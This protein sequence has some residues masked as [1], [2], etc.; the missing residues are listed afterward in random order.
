MVSFSPATTGITPI[1]FLVAGMGDYMD[2]ERS[3]L[4][5]ELQ[6]HSTASNGIVADANLASKND[7]TKFLYVTNNIIYTLFKQMNLYLSAQTNTYAYEAFCETLLNYNH[8]EGET[9]LAPQ[10]WVNDLNVEELL[11]RTSGVNDVLTTAGW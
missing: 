5:V 7:N 6:L 9:L 4:K 11:T 2:F 10:G 8:E 3:Y 1:A